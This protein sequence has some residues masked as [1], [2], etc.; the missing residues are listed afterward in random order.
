MDSTPRNSLTDLPVHD[1]MSDGSDRVK[2]FDMDNE[3]IWPNE[4]GVNIVGTPLGS[5]LCVSSYLQ[6]KG[7]KHRLLLQC[8]QDVA[9]S[10]FPRKT[11]QMRKG[12]TIP[13]LSHILRLVQK[14][15]HS[16]GC[17]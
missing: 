4:D 9:V 13:R 14:N 6:G 11:E 15:Q 12:A 10:G 3:R 2:P 8:I 5:S 1:D 17:M 16:L 7:L